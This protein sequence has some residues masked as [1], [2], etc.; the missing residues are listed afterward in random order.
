MVLLGQ[1]GLRVQVSLL[2]MSLVQVSLLIMS[3]LRAGPGQTSI[4]GRW[5]GRETM[6]RPGE[7][8]CRQE[9][10]V[11]EG[12]Q[13]SAQATH[14]PHKVALHILVVWIIGNQREQVTL[15]V[16]P[17]V[18]W[19]AS[20]VLSGVSCF[21]PLRLNFFISKMGIGFYTYYVKCSMAAHLYVISASRRLKQE[22]ANLRPA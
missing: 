7:A 11:L 14:L 1:G 16:T 10:K 15:K 18:H 4:R 19:K 6:G 3:L 9:C 5:W 20:K 8:A 21:S 2:T 12:A 17:C 22:K 13:D